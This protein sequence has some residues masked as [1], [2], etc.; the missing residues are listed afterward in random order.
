MFDVHDGDRFATAR[1]STAPVGDRAGSR[2]PSAPALF[3]TEWHADYQIVDTPEALAV[4]VAQL[5]EQDQI[6]I[7]TETTAKNTVFQTA[8]HHCGSIAR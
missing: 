5:D 2:Y 4:L 6:S 7:D 1:R 3:G 8:R